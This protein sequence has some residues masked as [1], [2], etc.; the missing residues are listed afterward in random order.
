P[1]TSLLFPYTTLFRSCRKWRLL[2]AL[3][4]MIIGLVSS[5]IHGCHLPLMCNILNR[6]AGL[7]LAAHH[8]TLGALT[9]FGGMY[10][11]GFGIKRIED[12]KSTRLNSSHVK[13]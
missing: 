12:R 3:T 4:I 10:V 13:I 5:G 2:I 7:S 1:S 9:I 8:G 6:A 11:A